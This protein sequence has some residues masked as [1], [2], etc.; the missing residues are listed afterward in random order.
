[1]MIRRLTALQ[2]SGNFGGIIFAI[3]F[4]YNGSDFAKA[5]YVIGAIVIAV[6]V[7]SSW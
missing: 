6:N 4:R 3:V 1:M 2:A 7:S 5:M